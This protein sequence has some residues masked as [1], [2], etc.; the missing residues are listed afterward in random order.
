MHPDVLIPTPGEDVRNEFQYQYTRMTRQRGTL[1]EDAKIDSVTG[2]VRVWNMA[3]G[4]DPLAA[5]KRQKDAQFERDRPK[6]LTG[7]RVAGF[8]QKKRVASWNNR[9]W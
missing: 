6:S 4:L 1:Y 9:G 5:A 3:L 8:V 7:P 2:C